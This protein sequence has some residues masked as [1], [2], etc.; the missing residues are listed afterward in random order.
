[1]LVIK[2]IYDA[3]LNRRDTIGSLKQKGALDDLGIHDNFRRANANLAQQLA[4]R[5]K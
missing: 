5:A 1:M 4:K 3:Y 2:R